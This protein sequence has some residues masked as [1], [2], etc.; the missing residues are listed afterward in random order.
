MQKTKKRQYGG[1]GSVSRTLK[2]KV[3]K[4]IE[5]SPELLEALGKGFMDGTKTATE[6]YINFIK[7]F[8]KLSPE[9]VQ[10]LGKFIAVKLMN[11]L[12]EKAAYGAVG[13]VS[14]NLK[15]LK[16]AIDEIIPS[17]KEQLTLL[18]SQLS[19]KRGTFNPD[20]SLLY[21]VHQHV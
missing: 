16:E 2:S 10:N 5:I 6:N 15:N 11:R 18:N 8:N 19:A 4:A 7:S 21:K 13:V 1:A 20:E 3:T 9:N 17:T 14:Y 12:Y